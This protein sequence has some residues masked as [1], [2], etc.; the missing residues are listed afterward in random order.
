[1]LSMRKT[2]ARI[3]EEKEDARRERE[4]IARLRLGLT[5]MEWRLLEPLLKREAMSYEGLAILVYGDYPP[6]YPE[7]AVRAAAAGL[8]H[9]LMRYGASLRNIVQFGYAIEPAHK[10]LLR[11]LL[12]SG[13]EDEPW[14]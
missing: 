10:R 9:K 3:A 8:R 2:P 4:G 1:M 7:V 13:E 11:D 6:A 14:S 5:P 12:C